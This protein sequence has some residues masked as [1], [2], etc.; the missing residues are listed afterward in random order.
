MTTIGIICEYNPFHNG[1]QYHIAEIKKLFPDSRIICVMSGNYVQRG[2]VSIINKWDKTKIA[3]DYGIDLVVELPFVFASQGADIFCKGSI[4]ILDYLNVDYLVFGSECNDIALLTKLANI[5]QSSKYNDIVKSLMKEGL[6]YP[7]ATSKAFLHFDLNLNLGPNDTLGLGYIRE[8]KKLNSKIKPITIKRTNDYHDTNI[9]GVIASAKAIREQL[10]KSGDVSSLLPYDINKYKLHFNNDYF[11][12]LKYKIISENN[13]KQYQTVDEGI[14][15]R[16]K[17]YITKAKDFEDLVLKIKTKRYTYHK[18]S[19]ML[20][21]I[22]LSFTKE[23][24]KNLNDIAYIR[25]LGFNHIGQT[26]IKEIK[27]HC[28]IPIIS[29]YLKHPMLTLEERTSLIYDNTFEY[30]KKIIKK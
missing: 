2:E 28:P 24:A 25:I 3:L 29:K 4:S 16:I 7:T 17:K 5:Q 21:H 27:K 9:N 23:E 10:K 12:L 1:H 18:I 6:N 19:R 22:L 13:L 15:N 8:L 20:I 26:Y 30:D 14:E 11:T